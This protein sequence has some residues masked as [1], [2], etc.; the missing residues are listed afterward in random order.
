[1]L[2]QRSFLGIA[3][4]VSFATGL[5]Q[6]QDESA[7]RRAEIDAN[8]NET[9]QNLYSSVEG[10]E[11]LADQAVGYAV[12]SATKAG[13]GFSGGGGSGVA[14]D[15]GAGET[16]YMKMGMCRC[17]P[18]QLWPACLW[19]VGRKCRGR[20]ASPGRCAVPRALSRRSGSS[21]GAPNTSNGV[22]VP[23]PSESSVP[24]RSTCPG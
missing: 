22:V 20:R 17:N 3:A 10:A 21:Q 15:K 1:M 6:A 7:E 12:F 19:K 9:L 8:A 14:V 23:R 13:F 5:A 24:S 2:L 11:A 16:V 18:P 4:L